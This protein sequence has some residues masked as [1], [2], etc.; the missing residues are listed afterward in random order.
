MGAP[1]PPPGHEHSPPAG[2]AALP[3]FRP[4][5]CPD[6]DL[7]ERTLFGREELADLLVGRV[8]DGALGTAR[9]Q[10][11]I[12]G[13]RGSGKTHVL[14]VVHNRLRHAP[15]LAG[16]LFIARLPEEQWETPSFLHLCVQVLRCLAAA[17]PDCPAA[18]WEDRL[19]AGPRPA[20]QAQTD[21]AALRNVAVS[22]IRETI[23]D[24]VLLIILE[25][26]GDLFD[27]LGEQGQQEL[28]A[29]IQQYD[30]WMLLASSQS[31]MGAV[32]LR[33]EPFYGFFQLHRL[34]PLGSSGSLAFLRRLAADPKI[35]DS[36]LHGLLSSPLGEARVKAVHHL[37]GGNHRFLTMLYPFLAG[38]GLAELVDP[39]IRMVDRELTP[40]YQERLRALSPLQRALVCHLARSGPQ[41]MMEA[42]RGCFVT[43]QSASRQLRELERLGFVLLSRAGR[44]THCE[45]REPLLRMV[46]DLLEHRDG[47]ARLVV[48]VLRSWYAPEELL[49]LQHSE[50]VGRSSVFAKC[51]AEAI[52]QNQLAAAAGEAA[53]LP[54][55]VARIAGL[56]A[57]G[58]FSEAL[59]ELAALPAEAQDQPVA[60]ALRAAALAELGR[61]AEAAEA[62]QTAESSLD[63]CAEEVPRVFVLGILGN[64]ARRLRSRDTAVAHFR[65]AVEAVR[66]LAIPGQDPYRAVLAQMLYV[67]GDLLSDLG[68]LEEARKQYNEAL[69]I[70]HELAEARPEAYQ[71]DLGSA[72][73]RRGLLLLKMGHR[74]QASEDVKRAAHI[75]RDAYAKRPEADREKLVPLLL[76]CLWAIRTTE[77]APAA[78][79]ALTQ[80]TEGLAHNDP[81]RRPMLFTAWV[82]ARD[83]EAVLA[84]A[85]SSADW[86]RAPFPIEVRGAAAALA[87]ES[88]VPEC[89]TGPLRDVVEAVATPLRETCEE[90]LMVVVRGGLPLD[91]AAIPAAGQVAERIAEVFGAEGLPGKVIEL[92]KASI[93]YIEAG[94]QEAAILHLPVELR[95]LV[96]EAYEDQGQEDDGG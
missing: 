41:P 42:A 23:G 27:A 32:R 31:L 52:R 30:N 59:D 78:A 77:G 48:H 69:G 83:W 17:Y 60:L 14:T 76:K 7:L 3:T 62:F 12:H 15:E 26:L 4:Q 8:R 18:Q 71:A 20:R 21:F 64:C 38:D 1:T 10:Q 51:V 67:L 91:E 68:K 93:A 92:L 6:H 65:Q 47:V 43:E 46:L 55:W 24:G 82:W 50:A 74:A 63:R 57:R 66:G 35:G 88:L 86:A 29:T 16:K 5:A 70:W 45:V 37:C 72:L 9:H 2:P 13:P 28:R 34:E 61:D 84:S 85:R 89:P 56:F 95:R 53:E 36:R 79:E 19:H 54:D 75:L 96:L 73:H 22:L 58:A 11:L 39:F 40:F 49:E 80:F 44:Q 94:K 25:N 90:A 81:V 33:T 87:A